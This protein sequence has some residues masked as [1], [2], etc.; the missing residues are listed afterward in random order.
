MHTQRVAFKGHPTL[1]P[2]ADIEEVIAEELLCSSCAPFP[3]FKD[4]VFDSV[5]QAIKLH[6]VLKDQLCT[7]S[8]WSRTIMPPSAGTMAGNGGGSTGCHVGCNRSLSWTVLDG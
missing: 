2:T 5:Q 7:S 6:L 3:V 8:R 1:L 4:N